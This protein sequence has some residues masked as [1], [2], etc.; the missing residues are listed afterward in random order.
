MSDDVK[1]PYQS[2][3]RAESAEQTRQLIRAAAKR[4]FETRGVTAT[5]MRQVAAEAG[6]AERTVY[7]AFPTKTALF[8]EVVNI[9]TVGDDRPVP[10]ADRA[11]FTDLFT[12]RD[13]RRAVQLMVGFGTALLDR[14][15]DLI[16]AAIESSGADADMREFCERSSAAN[17]ANMLRL[18]RAWA[19]NGL[20]RDHL[21]AET[22]ATQ[23]HTLCSPHVHHL[24]RRDQGW[25]S[26]RYRA[27]LADTLLATV[28]R[29]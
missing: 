20:L 1:R 12:E 7:T 22:A 6:V 5:T 28:L 11:A 14:A 27:W 19:D 24:L 4:L 2:R 26:D 25:S 15:G 13:P 10:V 21:D 8:N 17:K 3:R 9:A 16:M 23:L 18:A 29:S